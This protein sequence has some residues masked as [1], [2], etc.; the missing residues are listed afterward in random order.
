MV[1]GDLEHVGNHE[2]EALRGGECGS[3]STGLQCTMK[4][5]GSAAFTL[6]FFHDGQCAPDISLSFRA[7]LIGPLGHW[8]RGGDGVDGDDFGETIGD[9]GGGL[10]AIKNNHFSS[11]LL[12]THSVCLIA[13]PKVINR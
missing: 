13:R 5:T 6:Q 4:G 7:P 9:R 8:R 12:F 11:L 3:E 1:A 10:V 2:Q